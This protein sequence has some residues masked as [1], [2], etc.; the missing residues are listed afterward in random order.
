MENMNANRDVFGLNGIAGMLIA[1][2]LLIAI[3]VGLT[4]W[5]ISAQRYIANK[6]YKI[7]DPQ[8]IEKISKDNA[9]LI[10]TVE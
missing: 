3:L 6:P 1:T 4:I 5:G 8:A 10:K 9:N 7:T 2:L